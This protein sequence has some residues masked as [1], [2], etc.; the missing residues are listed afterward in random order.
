MKVSEI[1]KVNHM[2][3]EHESILKLDNLYQKLVKD[4]FGY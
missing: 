3:Y 1:E 4:P 2:H